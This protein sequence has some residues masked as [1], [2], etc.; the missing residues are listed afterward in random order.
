MECVLTRM[1][2][3]MYVINIMVVAFMYISLHFITLSPVSLVT[4]VTDYTMSLIHHKINKDQLIS[5]AVNTSSPETISTGLGTLLEWD[6]QYY[7]GLLEWDRQCTPTSV[8]YCA[9]AN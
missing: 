1:G 6:R 3:C 7:T 8:V 5:F 4:I 2:L 9:C